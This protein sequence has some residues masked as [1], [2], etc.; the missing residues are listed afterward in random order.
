MSTIS[1]SYI[2]DSLEVSESIARVF[3]RYKDDIKSPLSDLMIH[4]DRYYEDQ[5]SRSVDASLL[6]KAQKGVGKLM[7]DTSG[8]ESPAKK[9]KTAADK[10]KDKK[11]AAAAAV[12]P[13]G[14]K[15]NTT[16]VTSTELTA[17]KSK[18]CIKH[19]GSILF[20]NNPR[21]GC[22]T[23][24][25]SLKHCVDIDKYVTYFGSKEALKLMVPYEMVEGLA[26]LLADID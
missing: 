6:L 13:L 17:G 12:G 9:P 20:P 19:M 11:I 16:A 3:A 26:E 5:E 15:A 24:P 1:V 10:K 7:I 8:S 23:S 18:F 21:F 2:T 25:C 14:G 22:K 4:S